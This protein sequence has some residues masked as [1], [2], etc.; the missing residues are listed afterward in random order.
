MLKRKGFFL[1][2]FVCFLSL[3]SILG[4]L[5]FLSPTFQFSVGFTSLS[6]FPLFFVFLFLFLFS[7]VAVLSRSKKHGILLGLFVDSYLLLRLEKLTH[8]FFLVLL[9]AIFLA[10]E[11]LF[12]R[13]KVESHLQSQ[14][15]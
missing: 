1:L 15:S 7:L 14:D 3:G 4:L 9:A 8:P 2:L 10:L 13:R 5:F 6:I 12:T 11:L